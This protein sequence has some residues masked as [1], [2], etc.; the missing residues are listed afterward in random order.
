[1]CG[2]AGL[3][4]SEPL[5]E[6]ELLAAAARMA[7]TIVHRGPDDGG[8]WCATTSGVA[9]GFRRLSIIDLSPL[10]HQP[11]ASRSGRFTLM[12]NGEIYNFPDLRREL[13]GRG[14]RFR[15][16]S[17]TEI[18]LAAFEEWGIRKTLDRLI[19]MFAMAVWDSA[20]RALTL[21]RDR[22]GKKPL[23]V[24]HQP[25]LVTFGSELKAL[26]AG[27]SF[28][29]TLDRDAL[30]LYL[31]YLY[32]PAPR[33]IYRAVTKI[34][35]GH[36]LTISDPRA[37]L[38][39][40]TPYWSLD[41]VARAG[42][43]NPF[44]GSDDEAVDALD[45]LLSD[46]VRSRMVADVPLGALLSGGV[47]SSAVVALMQEAASR[48]VRTYTIGFDDPAHNEAPHARAIAN[49]L[50]TDHTE[51]VLSGDDA[52]A[53]V[54]RLATTFDEPLADPSQIPTYLVSQLARR[55]VTVA[56]VGDGGDELFGGYNRYAYGVRSLGRVA[57]M[58]RAL[59][60][61]AAA[62]INALGPGSWDRLYRPLSTL[63]PGA[64]GY[65]LVGEKL[66]KLAAVMNAPTEAARYRSLMSA[67]Q[68][69][70][71]LVGGEDIED[72]TLRVLRAGW[73]P[74]LLDRMM[75]ADQRTYLPDDLLAKVDRASMA[76]S[77]E[78]RAPLLDHRL[79][80]FAWRLP[81]SMKLR[82]GVT[83]W[84]LREVLYRRV[85]RHLIDRP[86]TGFS[87]PID[88]W[89]RGPLRGWAE[90]LLAGLPALPFLRQEP[91]MKAWRDMLAR[92]RPAGPA[93]WA[94]LSFLDWQA[95]WKAT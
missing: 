24:Y 93:L 11:M 65:R 64:G 77:L 63:L 80:E 5:R 84:V 27:P 70:E 26:A 29:R 78:V 2:L 37:P 91:V 36:F 89:L 55:H 76:V 52:L 71:M 15:G 22:V 19:G 31:R 60:R 82:D 83:K 41:E 59:R 51:L 38:P 4:S 39:A 28:D 13:E 61:F 94:L 12:F 10:G 57:V 73:P 25:G 43:Q 21:I 44:S 66:H 20:E 6:A 53:L 42:L 32:V 30:A 86:K 81:A 68:H 88:A 56:L 49:Y 79:V 48:P 33:S 18:V 7:D 58:P 50:G 34:P 69:P 8:T 75:L 45:S 9:F 92:R 95:H 85:P 90:D 46:A 54:P 16:H 14:A 72:D 17:D 1:M 74:Q 3:F 47:D 67:W 62:G 87:V 35:A 23:F 40:T